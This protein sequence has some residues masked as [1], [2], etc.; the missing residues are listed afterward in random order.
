M[1]WSYKSISEV[2]GQGTSTLEAGVPA[3]A[4]SEVRGNPIED[5]ALCKCKI[6]LGV[7]REKS[8]TI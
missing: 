4:S 3:E 2:H 1:G 7:I 6:K 8:S 5:W